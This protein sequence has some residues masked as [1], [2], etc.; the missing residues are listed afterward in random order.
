MLK[1]KSK[2]LKKI[3]GEILITKYGINLMGP[4][5]DT[6]LIE[7][8]EICLNIFNTNQ[9]LEPSEKLLK[10]V[11]KNIPKNP[12]ANQQRSIDNAIVKLEEGLSKPISAFNVPGQILYVQKQ[13]EK[14]LQ[15]SNI[16]PLANAN[17]ET[18]L[19]LARDILQKHVFY[20]IVYDQKHPNPLNHSKETRTILM[21][22][23]LG[24]VCDVVKPGHNYA[25]KAYNITLKC[26]EQHQAYDEKTVNSFWNEMFFLEEKDQ[27]WL[28]EEKKELSFGTLFKNIKKNITPEE[29]HE[30]EELRKEFTK[31]N[32]N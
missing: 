1:F 17:K 7:L 32:F 8:G 22:I 13:Y 11:Y 18:I 3:F 16:Y 25:E 15:A 31:M 12:T 9:V 23:F 28:K 5:K 20:T 14:D 10:D 2:H 27:E 19:K 4:L 6:S 29:N 24:K 30:L 26:L 21:L